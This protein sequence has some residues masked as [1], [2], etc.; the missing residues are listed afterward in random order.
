M[1]SYEFGG[2]FNLN[3]D[4]LLQFLPA[5]VQRRKEKLPKTPISKAAPE[6]TEISYISDDTYND[7]PDMSTITKKS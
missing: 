2:V 1:A 7:E 5:I 4:K 6:S 3:D